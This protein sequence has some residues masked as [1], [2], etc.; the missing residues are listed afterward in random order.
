[1]LQRFILTIFTILYSSLLSMAQTYTG[2]IKTE[3]GKPLNSVSIILYGDGNSIVS[4][5]RTDSKGHFTI[6]VPNGKTPKVLSFN[7]M[8]YEK[9][10]LSVADFKNESIIVL[11]EKAMQIKEVTV[12]AQRLKSSG[13]TLT[14]SV[15]GFRQKQD[16]TIA[17]VIAKMPGLQV[18]DNGTIQYQGKNINKFYIEGM[19]LLGGQYSQAS[20]NLSADKVVSVQVLENHQPIKAL[21]DTK[22]S[23]QAALNLVLKDKAKDVWTGEYTLGTGMQM[24]ENK[25]WL[26][27]VKLMEM[28]FSK[29]KQSISMYKGNNTGKDIQREV[30]DLTLSENSAPTENGI[31]YNI[32]L[33]ATLLKAERSRLNDT[34]LFATNW[35]FRDKRDNDW[36]IQLSAL[37]DKSLHHQDRQTTYLD[38]ADSA[39]ISEASEVHSIRN[40]WKG[41][42]IY[43]VNKANYYLSHELKGYMDF[44]RSYGSS[45]LNQKLTNQKVKPQKRYI[46]DNIE[47]IKN[48]N[49]GK[50]FSFASL[51][52]YNYLPGSLLVANDSVAKINMQTILWESFFSFGHRLGNINLKYKGGFKTQNQLLEAN[53]RER[54]CQYQPYL[55]TTISYTNG[56]YR[57]NA[58][59]PISYLH[60][61]FTQQSKGNLLFQPH[62][63]MSY[64]IGKY[65]EA[66]MGYN[67]GWMPQDIKAISQQN[68]YTSYITMTQGA[69]KLKN[70]TSHA[71]SASLKYRNIMTSV[72]ANAYFS[73]DK[74]K[75]F[76]I[77]NS[78]LENNIYVRRDA[79]ETEDRESYSISGNIGKAFGLGKTKVS[80]NGYYSWSNY[81][82]LINKIPTPQHSKCAHIDLD[83]SCKLAQWLSMEENSKWS[84]SKNDQATA[85]K[86]YQHNLKVF[87]MPKNWQIEWNNECYHSNDKS[88]SFTYFCDLSVFYRT[89]SIEAGITCNN[90][91]GAKEFKRKFF[92][93]NLQS[94]TITR[95]RPREIICQVRFSL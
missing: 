36:K 20:E 58:F 17:D 94:Y 46:V 89:N 59:A 22:F 95:L 15:A 8:G 35:L 7:I 67:F 14:Y 38:V 43:K 54:Y 49:K 70:T 84:Y 5:A 80:L 78:I 23:E 19:D 18:K 57:I 53:G 6:N 61:T 13:D 69:G 25:E 51:F 9:K 60:R 88:V 75:H 26:R 87:I 86:S 85:F 32:S 3:K 28:L 68:I 12:K 50:S 72:F 83:F 42:L 34:H 2:S 92:T 16:R 65:T 93:D 66:T 37:W 10:Q 81:Y 4:F 33:P 24:Q 30:S 74:M 52:S 44:N 90:I 76:S 48:N 77:Y 91:C 41:Q 47:L 56:T 55:E 73:Y 45:L 79:G 82:L 64:Y 1:M 29:K 11:K 63:Y 21:K 39:Q 27:D 31:L 40:E 71:L 62:I